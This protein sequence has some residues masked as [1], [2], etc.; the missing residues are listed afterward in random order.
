MVLDVVGS[1]DVPN[2]Y[3]SEQMVLEIEVYVCFTILKRFKDLLQSQCSVFRYRFGPSATLM[4]SAVT[5]GPQWSPAKTT[6]LY[7]GMV[8][9]LN[10]C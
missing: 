7:E 1:S 6:M 8:R 3:A 10:G 5:S 9:S 2:A 4:A